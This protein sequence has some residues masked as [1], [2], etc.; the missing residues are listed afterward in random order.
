MGGSSCR[1]RSPRAS[2]RRPSAVPRPRRCGVRRSGA[3]DARPC[4]PTIFWPRPASALELHLVEVRV[5]AGRVVERRPACTVWL[6]LARGRCRGRS[7]VSARRRTRRRARGAARGAAALAEQ[8]PDRVLGR[9]VCALAEV[10]VAHVPVA[11]DQVVG[12]PVLVGPRVPGLVAVVDGDRI[13]DVVLATTRST[14]PTT[15]SNA[16]SGVCTP[17][18]TR[19]ARGSGCPTP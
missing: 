17:T 4:P 11:I 6:Y 5:A 12:R 2:P 8:R 16:N 18:I 13:A 1:R 9:V 19:P 10:G 15:C 3:G 14:L 7:R